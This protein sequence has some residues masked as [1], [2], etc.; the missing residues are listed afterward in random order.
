MESDIAGMN[1]EPIIQIERAIKK[2]AVSLSSSLEVYWPNLGNN[3]MSEIN[4]TFQLGFALS[5]EGYK[6]FTEVSLQQSDGTKENK[7]IDMLAIEPTRSIVVAVECK[8]LFDSDGSR[9]MFEDE[10]RLRSF[11]LLEGY[12][13]SGSYQLFGVLLATTWD[14]S[15]ADWWSTK[16]PQT[17]PGKRKAKSWSDLGITLNSSQA[18]D[19]VVL[20]HSHPLWDAN[21][22]LLYA[23]QDYGKI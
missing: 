8:R 6:I 11:R 9:S 4:T 23:I 21:H 20:S 5:N 18:H 7:H 16:H 3:E 13:S 15:I 2:A 14:E 19:A 17:S 1:T 10:K 12:T 22:Y